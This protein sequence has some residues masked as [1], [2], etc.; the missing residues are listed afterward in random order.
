M[1]SKVEQKIA[2]KKKGQIDPKVN[3]VRQTVH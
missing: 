2:K 3:Y 1:A